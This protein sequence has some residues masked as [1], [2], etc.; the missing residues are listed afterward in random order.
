M[1]NISSTDRQ[2][3]FPTG[4]DVWDDWKQACLDKNCLSSPE[5]IARKD[6]PDHVIMMR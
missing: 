3:A 4:F 1:M 5:E 6:F 2:K